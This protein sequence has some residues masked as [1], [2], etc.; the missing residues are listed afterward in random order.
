MDDGHA[1]VVQM[2]GMDRA[3]NRPDEVHP[4]VIL[5]D[6]GMTEMAVQALIAAVIG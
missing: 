2:A 4:L 3:G 6:V 1:Q 5:G